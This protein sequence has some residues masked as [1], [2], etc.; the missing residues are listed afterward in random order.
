M[1]SFGAIGGSLDAPMPPSDVPNEAYRAYLKSPNW[2][3][4]KSA[5]LARH[6]R[7][8]QACGSRINLD[9][10]HVT[11]Q[12]FG[13]E[14]LDDLRVLCRAH[15]ELVHAIASEVVT[16]SDATDGV[17]AGRVVL[18]PTDEPKVERP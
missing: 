18:P 8:C 14:D 12:R 5:A 3:V 2:N 16:L 10:H 13:D 6:G 1:E 11:Y 17:I 15:H 7:K 9:V 4:H